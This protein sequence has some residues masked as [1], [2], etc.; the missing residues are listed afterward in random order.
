MSDLDN[1][2]VAQQ[3]QHVPKQQNGTD[4]KKSLDDLMEKVQILQNEIQQRGIKNILVQFIWFD[5]I[6][7]D[8]L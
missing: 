2:L 6:N 7:C 3:D 5:L 8:I 1:P 4:Y